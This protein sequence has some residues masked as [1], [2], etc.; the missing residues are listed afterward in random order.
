VRACSLL[1]EKK[2]LWICF[3]WRFKGGKSAVISEGKLDAHLKNVQPPGMW[4]GKNRVPGV[5][6]RVPSDKNRKQLLFLHLHPALSTCHVS[7][8]TFSYPFDKLP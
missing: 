8:A 4:Q 3:S 2:I 6:Y 1:E 5:E 7:F